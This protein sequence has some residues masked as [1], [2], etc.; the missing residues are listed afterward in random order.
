MNYQE[1]L[2]YLYRSTPVFQHVGGEAY[3]EGLENSL[4]LDAYLGH[5]HKSYRTIHVGG[6]NGKG[7]TS[8]I[9]SSV[10]QQSGYKVGLYTSPHLRDF[11]ERIRVNGKKI[12]EQFVV[13]FVK[14]H[15]NF[16]ETI[17]PSFFELTMSMAFD[18]FAQRQVD[19]AVVEVG[20]GGKLDS[21]NIIYPELSVI[22][23]ISF[24]HTQF[25]GDTLVKIAG[26]KAGIIKTGVPVVIGEAEGDVRK[27]FE[28]KAY[29]VHAPVVFAEDEKFVRKAT[30]LPNGKFIFDTQDYQDLIGEL[31]GLVQEKNAN[32]ILCAIHELN[33]KGIDIKKEAVYDGFAHVVEIS[34]LE[35]RWQIVS[36][37]PKI[38][39]DAGHN[40][41][42][43]I[44]I[45]KQLEYEKYE[46]LHFI[47][48]TVNDKDITGILKLLPKHAIY[49][50]TK[51]SVVR[52]LDE[53]E[54]AEKAFSEGLT[55]NIF[56]T[57]KQAIIAAKSAASTEDLIF[58]GGSNF[59]VA[60]ALV[61]L[62]VEN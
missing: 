29:S 15:Q 28:E 9:L 37:S 22:T 58:I 41:G 56:P 43:I 40:T 36:D 11:R 13:D 19:I 39:L 17:S 52:A 6:T 2:A 57:V 23:N 25:L 38:I 4:V 60:D 42:G 62:R 3:K 55:G 49:Y 20:L 32:T 16:F 45:A 35:G 46:K 18:Y 50:F 59:I 61:E 54:L 24:D 30:L 33:K 44:Y 48:G 47:I 14:K 12:E 31:G 53:K 7:S 8:H 10:L 1:T 51:A 26:E 34:G 27:V 5:P 21:T